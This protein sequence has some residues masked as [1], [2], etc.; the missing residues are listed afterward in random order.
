LSSKVLIVSSNNDPHMLAVAGHLRALGSE[1]V[2]HDFAD[3]IDEGVEINIDEGTFCIG[4]NDLHDCTGVYLRRMFPL[5]SSALSKPHL[6]F[7]QNEFRHAALGRLLSLD[8]RWVSH[9]EALRLASF[10][11]RQ[12]WLAKHV[13][14]LPIPQTLITSDTAKAKAFIKANR[15]T[16][17]IIKCL[18]APVIEYEDETGC[19]FT[20]EVTDEVIEVLDDLSYSPCIIQPLIPKAFEVRANVVGNQM[21]A[22]KI[23]TTGVEEARVDWRF[24]KAGELPHSR[25]ELPPAIE[26]ACIGM[27]RD[28]GLKFGAFDFLV[29][30]EAN[31]YFLEVNP[32]GQWWWVEELVGHPIAAAI[33]REL[34]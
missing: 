32:N 17:T 1:V 5:R 7:A 27:T 12:Y 10:K 2:Q 22:A 31:W 29:D 3:L 20:N 14:A 26:Q 21:F 8:V 18:G 6:A 23:D 15:S 30:H 34:L 28:L 13:Y 24:S 33:A 16:G 25:I 9:P 11:A 4:K 19:F